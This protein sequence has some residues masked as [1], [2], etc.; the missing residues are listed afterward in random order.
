MSHNKRI[1]RLPEVMEKAAEVANEIITDDDLVNQPKR[2]SLFGIP[3]GGLLPAGLVAGALNTAGYEAGITDNLEVATHFIDDIIDSG[4]TSREWMGKKHIPFYALFDAAEETDWI[5]FPWEQT[6]GGDDASA[7]DIPVRLLQFVGEDPTRGGLQETP[8][9]FL[10]AWQ[11]WTSGYGVKDEDIGTIL[12]AFED[13]ADKCDEMVV[14]TNIPVYSQCEHH[15]A[16]FFGVAHIAYIP[17]GKIVGLSKMSRLVEVYAR[18]L[19]VQERLTNQ[20]ADALVKHLNP[21]GVGVVLQCRH[22]CMESR[23][24]QQQGTS[25]TTSALRGAMREQQA[26]RDEFMRLING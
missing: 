23:G 18:R 6:S 15:L 25:T 16:P 9:R 24:I 8:K 4:K 13:G 19:Q 5:V 22:M 26:T 1:I 14:Q 20:I 17:N 2:V 11:F 12:K 3:R 7:D 21:V 10:K